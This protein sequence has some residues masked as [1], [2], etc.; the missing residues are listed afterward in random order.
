MLCCWQCLGLARDSWEGRAGGSGPAHP[1]WRAPGA[2]AD[3]VTWSFEWF[4]TLTDSCWIFLVVF[5]VMLQ[6]LTA[7][8]V[9]KCIPNIWSKPSLMQLETGLS[10]PITCSLGKKDWSPPVCNL[11][12]GSCRHNWSGESW[13]KRNPVI[14]VSKI[15]T[16]LL[17]LC[18]FLTP[19]SPESRGS[20][21]RSAR[22]SLS[23]SWSRSQPQPALQP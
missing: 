18:L 14:F 13:S 7:F 10:C 22:A 23:H 5:L 16:W 6:C 2:L 19:L 12:L 8:S 4:K 11:L 15:T 21:C 1:L 20:V 17:K 3:K 9:N